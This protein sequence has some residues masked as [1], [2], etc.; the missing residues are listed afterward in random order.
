M[1]S[2]MQAAALFWRKYKTYMHRP[3]E[4]AALIQISPSSLR[5]WCGTFAQFLSAGAN[6]GPGS[7]RLLN[8]QD[9][10]IL[11][12][13][14]ELRSQHLSYADVTARLQN[15]DTAELQPY[16][17]LQPATPV[18]TPTET[19]TEANLPAEY[20]IQIMASLDQ[21]FNALQARID[22]QESK[23]ASRLTHLVFGFIAGVLLC[24]FVLL[25][26]WLLR[27]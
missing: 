12:R 10:A 6:P 15:E 27:G 24:V 22:T 23:N 21:R 2:I 18:Q 9:I 8:D 16:I 17:D 14:K 19:P 26:F 13:V 20:A 1:A 25:V 11:Q 5:S 4:A 7:E 3:T